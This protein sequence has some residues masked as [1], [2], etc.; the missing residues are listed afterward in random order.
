MFLVLQ[1]QGSIMVFF[2][3]RHI[4]V[5]TKFWYTTIVYQST[6]D[7]SH[8]GLSLYPV[9]DFKGSV[10]GEDLYLWRF[11]PSQ[12]LLLL[13]LLPEA[14]WLARGTCVRVCLW[15]NLIYISHSFVSVLFCIHT[16]SLVQN[17]STCLLLVSFLCKV[18]QYNYRI[19]G[20]FF[21]ETRWQ[22]AEMGG[23]QGVA[24][25]LLYLGCYGWLLGLLGRVTCQ[26]CT[27]LM[28]LSHAIG[29]NNT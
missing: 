3:F 20:V 23:C 26:K 7:R 5:C 6:I 8:W 13:T 22:N 11:C 28:L 10:R 25:R 15:P 17:F 21:C 1:Y 18:K 29:K 16:I 2:L 27:C 14:A 19:F 9:S 12:I 4:G 24:I